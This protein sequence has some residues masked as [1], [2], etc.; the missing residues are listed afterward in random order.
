MVGT[1]VRGI[2]GRGRV[3]WSLGAVALLAPLCISCGIDET[4]TGM[5]KGALAGD[6]LNPIPVPATVDIQIDIQCSGGNTSTWTPM[7]VEDLSGYAF[8]F[9]TLTLS[10]PITG[11]VGDDLNKFFAESIEKGELNVLMQVADHDKEGETILFNIGAGSIVSEEEYSFTEDPS[12]LECE[13]LGGKFT[14]VTPS[15]LAFPNSLITPPKLPISQVRLGGVISADGKSITKGSLVGA[16]TMEDAQ[17]IKMGLTFD[18]LLASMSIDPNL[19]L[20]KDGT[21]DAWLFEGAFE[22]T[23]VEV[24]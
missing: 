2:V 20:D 9:N 1:M 17:S 12:E 24:K 4:Y 10:K 16:L 23:A 5:G 15:T 8:R 18:K 3:A 19:D 22:A 14:T 21:M 6:P 11:T 7:D 13:A